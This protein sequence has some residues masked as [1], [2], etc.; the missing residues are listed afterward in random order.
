MGLGG[1]LGIDIPGEMGG[2][3]PNSAYL[4]RR[5]RIGWRPLTIIWTGMGQ[6]DI[7]VTPLQ[8][9]NLAATI[10]NRAIST[11]HTYTPTPQNTH[12]QNALQS[13]DLR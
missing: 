2:L 7:T 4:A 8:L 9:C 3:V 13:V 6:G 12:Y 10:A 5:Y 1:P 11:H